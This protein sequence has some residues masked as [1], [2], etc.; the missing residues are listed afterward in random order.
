MKVF[1]I[2]MLEAIK[3]S[4][5][6]LVV[7]LPIF[8][9]LSV[10]GFPQYPYSINIE[11]VII[12]DATVKAQ[13]EIT[14]LPGFEASEGLEY[15]ALIDPAFPGSG[16]PYVEPGVAGVMQVSPSNR[17]YIMVTAPQTCD[18]NGSGNYS[19][20][21]ISVDIQ[22]F[23][24][25][26]R[27]MQDVSVMGS[28]DQKDVIKVFTYDSCGRLFRTYIPYESAS[29]TNGSCDVNW[30]E[31]QRSFTATLFGEE[32]RLYGYSQPMYEPSPLDRIVKQSSPGYLWTFQ[33]T[34]PSLEHVMDFQYL[35]NTTSV[36]S[37]R[38]TQNN[39]VEINYEEGSLFITETANENRSDQRGFTLE[40]KNKSGEKVISSVKLGSSW[41]NTHY[42]YDD[43]GLLRCVV[44]PKAISPTDSPDL[45]YFY[46][47][48]GRKRLVCKTLPGADSVL[49]IFDKRDRLV[50]EQDGKMRAEN[51]GNW[52]L[53]CY[54]AL[55]RPVMQGVYFHAGAGLSQIQMQEWFT[56]HVTDLNTSLNGIYNDIDHGYN[57]TVV[58]QLGGSSATYEVYSVTYYD[59]YAFANTNPGPTHYGFVSGNGLVS[60]E[61]VISG[62]SLITGTKSKVIKR[63]AEP[64]L[65]N[66]M[67]KAMYYD[68][69]GRVVQTVSDNCIYNGMDVSTTSY[70]FTGRIEAHKTWH[71]AFGDTISFLERFRYDH[72]GRLLEH[73]LEGFP[74]QQKVLMKAD[75]YNA[76]GQ[77]SASYLHAD[78]NGSGFLPYMQRIDYAYNI[79]G[80]L[81]GINQPGTIALGDDLF[82][83][84]LAYTEPFFGSSHPAQFNGNLSAIVWASA[85]E[86]APVGYGFSYDNVSRLTKAEFYTA[87]DNGFAHDG[88]F[89]ENNISYDANGNLLTLQRTGSEQTLIDQLTYSYLGGG[90]QVAFIADPTFDVPGVSDY[91]GSTAA[92]QGYW[93]DAN[94]NMTRCTDKGINTAI[95]Y[96]VFNKPEVIDFGNGEKMC[97]LY[98]GTGEK[99]ARTVKE[100]NNLLEGSGVYAGR[101][102]YDFGGRLLYILTDDGRL[103]PHGGKYRFE[104]FLKDHLGNTRVRCAAAAPGVAMAGEY[105][106]YY[107]FGLEIEPQAYSS[108]IG[109]DNRLR[110]NGK[111]IQPEF[112]LGWYDYGFRFYDPQIGRWHVID[113]MVEN[114]HHDYTPYAYAYN[115]PI[116]Y[117][118]QVGLDTTIYVFDQGERP[119]DNGTKGET[120]TAEIYID[121]DGEIVGPYSGSSYPNSKSNSDNSTS[122][123]TVKDGEHKYNNE[124]GHDNGTKKGLNI[125]DSNNDSR[126][127]SGTNP[128]GEDVTMTGVN[129]H[130]GKSDNGNYNSRGSRGCVTINPKD[131]EAFFNNFDWSKNSAQTKGNSSGTI[132]IH[133][134]NTASSMVDKLLINIKK[135]F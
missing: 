13:Y 51:P 117:I 27:K 45:C 90:N 84:K 78:A 17:N 115:N 28:P 58:T 106:H 10:N 79:R 75:R 80:W 89:E 116:L 74:G 42:I 72:R 108:V 15:T 125:D 66:W 30:L 135:L 19:C 21:D 7:F 128:K 132:V 44:P 64:I 69:E 127:A 129:V 82:A 92:T 26:G 60:D 43:F 2:Q 130:E 4:R 126:T 24:G 52:L 111:E 91:P 16:S 6:F 3:A 38:L 113:P 20:G 62:R 25:L 121:I 48:D 122:S 97:Y 8:N 63:E 33:P 109:P 98:D 57:R 77:L 83:M 5:L 86:T 124:S 55:N 36:P 104:Y 34:N 39:Y 14:H 32:N 101:F 65:K 71:T 134:G 56:N 105:R 23:D 114:N 123:N 35:S 37:W 94:G 12:G 95:V 61:E 31:N 47:Y 46:R 119:K 73:T 41:L 99:I 29:A 11:T 59:Q 88:S 102:V 100:G 85:R 120:Y 53:T 81:T 103:V 1:L 67:V 133:R 131:S 49:Q 54:D 68:K 50:M 18:Y 96:S 76:V 40:F 9:F 22:Y 107:P 87:N 70:S 112:G 93:Y 118:D 110:Y